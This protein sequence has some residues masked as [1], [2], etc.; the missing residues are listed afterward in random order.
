MNIQTP[1]KPSDFR[2][3]QASGGFD[4]RFDDLGI[5][6]EG[7]FCAGAF[8]GVAK[9][10]YWND[11]EEGLSWFVGDILLNCSKWNGKDYD[12]RTITLEQQ[13]RLY[14]PIWSVLTD[15][16]FKDSIDARVREAM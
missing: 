11:P 3:L 14:I 4:F 13:D 2:L 6:V 16:S 9:V 1:S 7:E 12:V 5:E 10:T 8:N 15:G